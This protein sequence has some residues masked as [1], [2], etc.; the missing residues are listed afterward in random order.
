MWYERWSVRLVI[1]CVFV[2]IV[3]MASESFTDAFALVSANVLFA[4]WTLVTSIFLHGSV[5]HLLYNM[6][7]L[8][9]F[10]M[11]LESIIGGKKFLM[12]FFS[13]GIF[14][15]IGAALFYPSAI[16]ASGAIFAILG[17]LT[18]LR[19]R[20]VVWVAGIPMPMFVAAAVW[21]LMDLVGMFAPG[22]TANAAHLFGLAFGLV[23]G[24]TLVK[25]FREERRQKSAG[26][27]SRTDIDNWERKWM[28]QP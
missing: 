9:L 21:A 2:F 20:M 3:Q 4:P 8:A 19:P 5:D 12:L 6:F 7:A 25:K 24:Y 11:I 28:V 15:S 1:L 13:G 26:P 23:Y 10:G 14:A 17:A 27:L 18:I 22:Q 16:G